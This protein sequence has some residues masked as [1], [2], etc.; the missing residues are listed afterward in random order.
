M[1]ESLKDNWDAEAKRSSRW[2]MYKVWIG[3]GL[4]WLTILI[5]YFKKYSH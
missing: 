5:L 3:V 4:I 1:F 2:T